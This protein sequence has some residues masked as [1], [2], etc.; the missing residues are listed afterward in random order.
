M[1]SATKNVKLLFY[2]PLLP[3]ET[4]NHST[5]VVL[6]HI[7]QRAMAVLTAEDMLKIVRSQLPIRRETKIAALVGSEC[8]DPRAFLHTSRKSQ[9]STTR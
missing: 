3:G 6:S 9:D 5:E 2:S 7:C 1:A 4:Y 8:I